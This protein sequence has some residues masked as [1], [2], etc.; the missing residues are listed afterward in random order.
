MDIVIPQISAVGVCIVVVCVLVTI[1]KSIIP[2]K[3][4]Y[5]W[6]PLFFSLPLGFMV[7]LAECGWHLTLIECSLIKIF[8][9]CAGSMASYDIVSKTIENWKKNIEDKNE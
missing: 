9:I 1:L 7:A 2:Y 3:P 6:L 5:V 4:I 8:S